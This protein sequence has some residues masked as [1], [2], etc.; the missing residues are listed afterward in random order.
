MCLR[1]CVYVCMCACVRFVHV[2]VS[3]TK[4]G[5][6]AHVFRRSKTKPNEQVRVVCSS[7]AAY[8]W[9]GAYFPARCFP[10]AYRLSVSSTLLP[11]AFTRL[12]TKFPNHPCLKNVQYEV[13]DVKTVSKKLPV[14]V[15][16]LG[17][18]VNIFL[19]S[20]FSPRLPSLHLPPLVQNLCDTCVACV[21]LGPLPPPPSL[22]PVLCVGGVKSVCGEP[23][24][25][26]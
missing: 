14:Y 15:K 16:S 2:G 18:H 20:I 25:L 17:K 5:T 24:D 7:K 12:V 4:P 21:F 19:P 9:F 10:C 13:F 6:N 8:R 23:D 22:G 26:T 1:A 3:S 11:L